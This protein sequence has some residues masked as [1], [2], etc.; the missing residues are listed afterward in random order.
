MEFAGDQFLAGA[1]LAEHQHIGVGR[2]DPVDQCVQPAHCRRSAEQRAV[3]AGV[4]GQFGDLLVGV[5]GLTPAG[6][7]GGRRFYRCH[8]PVVIPRLGDEIGGAALHRLDSDIDAAIGRNDDDDGAGV[9]HLDG[10]QRLEAF[11]AAALATRKIHVEQHD[12]GVVHP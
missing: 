1:V 2:R 9:E 8:Q 11:D 3:R 12:I 7:Q 10:L 5:Q 6:A 4:G